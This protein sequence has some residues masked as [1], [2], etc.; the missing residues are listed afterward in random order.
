MSVCYVIWKPSRL[1]LRTC[2]YASSLSGKTKKIIIIIYRLVVTLRPSIDLRTLGQICTTISLF[3]TNKKKIELRMST[4]SSFRD[5]I[6]S[7]TWAGHRPL[8]A[9][10]DRRR[11]RRRP[12]RRRYTRGSEVKNCCC[13]CKS[14]QSK[15]LH[16][17]DAGSSSTT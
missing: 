11:R 9:S 1:H 12:R 13:N 5:S 15:A 3:Y 6:F 8:Q 4:F 17:Y 16:I 7:W 10:A 14:T 2:L